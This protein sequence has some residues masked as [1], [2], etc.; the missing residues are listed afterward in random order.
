M[1]MYAHCGPSEVIAQRLNEDLWRI[2][3]WAASSDAGYTS[4]SILNLLFALL[5]RLQCRDDIQAGQRASAI[6]GLMLA[7]GYEDIDSDLRSL[8]V[9]INLRATALF[10]FAERAAVRH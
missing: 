7:G 3:I 5:W 4:R 2:D 9:G 6:I 8:L 10:T 1:T